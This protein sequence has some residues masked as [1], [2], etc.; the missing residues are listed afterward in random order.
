M[1]EKFKGSRIIIVGD[2]GF[3][4]T[5][6]NAKKINPNLTTIYARGFDLKDINSLNSVQDLSYLI[7]KSF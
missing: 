6:T 5:G 4:G 2:H 1:K 7:L 3:R